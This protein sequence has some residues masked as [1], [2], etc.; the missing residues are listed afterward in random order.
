MRQLLD[1]YIRAEESETLSQ[2]EDMTL[3]DLIVQKGQEATKAL[4]EDLRKNPEAMAETIESNVRKVIID[5]NDV[6]PQYYEYMSRLLNDLIEQRRKEVIDYQQYLERIVELTRQVKNPEKHSSYPEGIN[7]RALQALYDN[8]AEPEN[9]EAAEPQVGYKNDPHQKSRAT[10]ALEVDEAI[11]NS[12]RA[13][14]QG[15]KIKERKVRIAIKQVVNSDEELAQKLLA[16]ARE[17]DEYS[18]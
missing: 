6:N 2:L 13:L 3:I 16:I 17:Q 1:M 11:R 7:T 15:D 14:W 10:K 4:P 8:L 5:E 9:S 12:K 18:N